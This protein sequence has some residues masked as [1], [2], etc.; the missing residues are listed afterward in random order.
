MNDL[1]GSVV[2]ISG[3]ARGIGLATARRFEAAGAKVAVGDLDTALA[4]QVCAAHP[5][6]MVGLHLDVSSLSSFEEFYHGAEMR[7]GAVDVLVN[8]AGIMPTGPFLVESDALTDR[9]LAV[10]LRG[11]I[12]GCRLAGRHMQKRRSGVIINVASLAGLFGAPGLATYCASKFAVVGLTESLEHELAVFGVH[13]A[14]VLPAVVNTE[15]SAGAAYPRFMRPVIEVEPDDVAARIVQIAA[16]RGST[17]TVPRAVGP[18]VR[19]SRM[20][21]RRPRQA[22]ERIAGLDKAYTQADTA[23]RA[24]YHQRISG[25][26]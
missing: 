17:M 6:T 10:N 1:N 20:L 3:G 15:L 23:L 21:A 5:D 24:A 26:C 4:Q 7:F 18:L 19:L 16:R 22:L 9:I 11:V 12:N 8:N 13:V 14:A 2:A 25:Q